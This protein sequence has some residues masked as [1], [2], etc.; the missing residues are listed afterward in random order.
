[1]SGQGER[2]HC[3]DACG[4]CCAACAP[5]ASH[6]SRRHRSSRSSTAASLHSAAPNFTAL[7]AHVCARA[8]RHCSRYAATQQPRSSR[9]LTAGRRAVACSSARFRR[10][11]AA[12][13]AGA[14]P[15]G[16]R[17]SGACERPPLAHSPSPRRHQ[18]PPT[19]PAWAAG[20]AG[21][22][23]AG[24]LSPG[25]ARRRRSAG[26]AARFGGSGRAARVRTR[27]AADH[28]AARSPLARARVTGACGCGGGGQITPG[29]TAGGDCL[30]PPPCP[31]TV[32]TRAFTRNSRSQYYSWLKFCG[33]IVGPQMWGRFLRPRLDSWPPQSN[34]PRPPH[35]ACRHLCGRSD[36]VC[37][38][39]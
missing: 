1:M 7:D 23:R 5:T 30:L 18:H 15:A 16:C 19:Q 2:I 8:C 34:G 24:I 21:R 28:A 11:P 17:C 3:P 26:S 29:R 12:C 20:L 37:V 39:R 25:R 38:L 31:P 27:E 33:L 14:A 35:T 36:R 10:A 32:T 6:A 22:I 4:P 13:A 9:P